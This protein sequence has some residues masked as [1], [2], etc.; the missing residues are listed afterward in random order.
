MARPR[1]FTTQQVRA[2]RRRHEKG[3]KIN[4]IA[5]DLNVSFSTIKA[6]LDGRTY[7]DVN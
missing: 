6:I 3:E 5:N 2:I 4:S 7:A 1:M